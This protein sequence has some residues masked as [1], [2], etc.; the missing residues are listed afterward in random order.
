VELLKQMG[1][2]NVKALYLATGFKADWLDQ[3]YA[4]EPPK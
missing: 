2:T 1:F 4:A 3:G